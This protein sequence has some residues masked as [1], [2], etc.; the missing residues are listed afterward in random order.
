MKNL[1]GY[2]DRESVHGVRKRQVHRDRTHAAETTRQIGQVLAGD[3]SIRLGAASPEIR[4]HHLTAARDDVR[5]VDMTVEEAM[6]FAKGAGMTARGTKDG[7][8][9]KDG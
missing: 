4:D 5:Q 3:D 7:E 2:H 6:R 8:K 1:I 9:E